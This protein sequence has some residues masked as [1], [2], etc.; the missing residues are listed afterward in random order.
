[1]KR[2]ITLSNNQAALIYNLLMNH[3]VKDNVGNRKRHKF[4][5]VIEDSVFSY[6]GKAR[7]LADK[8]NADE[9]EKLTRQTA[10]YTFNDPEIYTFGKSLFE[11]SFATGAAQFDPT[12]RLVGRRPLTGRESKVYK[13]IEDAFMDVKEV[14]DKSDKK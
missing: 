5:E 8:N 11:Q 3:E 7:A 1:M 10:S 13:E 4:L 14:K 2:I 6:E 9:I 12:G